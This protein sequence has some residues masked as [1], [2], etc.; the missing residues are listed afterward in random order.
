MTIK[1]AATEL[2]IST[3]TLRRWEENGSLM[4]ER[5]PTTGIR[6]YHIYLIEQ[7]KKLLT[8][9][10][11]YRHHLKRLDELRV[12]L[13]KHIYTK[14][15]EGERVPLLDAEGF[16]KAYDEMEKWEK[17]FKEMLNEMYAFPKNMLRALDQIEEEK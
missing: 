14:P 5:E 11:K 7:W 2:G 6:L 8:L 3:K 9:D 10:R 15:R 12:N 17:E 1:Q 16:G 4:P 13:D